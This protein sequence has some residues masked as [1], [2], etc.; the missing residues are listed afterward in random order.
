MYRLR[1]VIHVL[2]VPTV[3]LL[4]LRIVVSVRLEQQGLYLLLSYRLESLICLT[5]VSVVLTLVQRHAPI[6]FLPADH[7]AVA[8]TTVHVLVASVSVTKDSLAIH[9]SNVLLATTI[10][11]FV[12]SVTQ[13]LVVHLTEVRH[14]L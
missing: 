9:A 12:H 11:L 2:L 8:A 6:V 5:C 7:V 3:L 14:F 10:G 4:E 1:N 13:Q